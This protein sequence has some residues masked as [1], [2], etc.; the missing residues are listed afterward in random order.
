MNK[1]LMALGLCLMAV[2][3]ALAQQSTTVRGGSRYAFPLPHQVTTNEDWLDAGN[4][5]PVGSENKYMHT[6]NG[7]AL[8]EIQAG[9][10]LGQNW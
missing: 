10:N 3:A 4:V 1:T 8:D 7:D 6:D 5:A 2:G 9:P